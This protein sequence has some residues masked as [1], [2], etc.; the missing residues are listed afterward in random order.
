M[1]HHPIPNYLVPSILVTIF[2]CVPFGIPAIVYAAKVDGL[3]SR[4][5]IAGAMEASN[6]AKLWTWISA[7]SW[8]PLFG[9]FFLVGITSSM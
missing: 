8:I 4:G 6:K 1:A 7:L 3:I 9:L 5:D 2:C